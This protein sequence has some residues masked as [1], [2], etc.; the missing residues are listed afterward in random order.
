MVPST[1]RSRRQAKEKDTYVF[2]HEDVLNRF[3]FYVP[4]KLDLNESVL[5]SCQY[6]LTAPN[7]QPAV[8]VLHFVLLPSG[9]L[10]AASKN[11][12]DVAPTPATSRPPPAA[13]PPDIIPENTLTTLGIGTDVV[14]IV[15]VVCG[16]LL[17]GLIVLFIVR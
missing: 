3:I 17:L 12:I 1:K 15:A 11:S 5:D 7:V 14:L 2:S 10:V 9:T 6:R 13:D 8:G 16:V 4:R